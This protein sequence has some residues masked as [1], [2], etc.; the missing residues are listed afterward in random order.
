MKTVA[1]A[2]G[3][4]AVTTISG[5]YWFEPKS[6]R[7]STLETFEDGTKMLGSRSLGLSLR[8]PKGAR[9]YGEDRKTSLELTW[10]S[11][12][13]VH[14]ATIAAGTRTSPTTLDDKQADLDAR[15]SSFRVV[16]GDSFEGG[17]ELTFTFRDKKLEKYVGYF[18]LRTVEGKT[19]ECYLSG[20]NSMDAVRE[21][22]AM[23]ESLKP[24]QP[25]ADEPQ[26]TASR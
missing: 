7:V 19:Y 18:S 26:Q 1:V 2:L 20:G 16:K 8:A 5:C 13:A 6:T 22:Q 17:Y 9:E 3:L 23:C 21:A 24:Y 4:I 11:S 10:G 25:A 14:Y 15:Y 12:A